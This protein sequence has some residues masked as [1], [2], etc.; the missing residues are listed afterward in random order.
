MNPLLEHAA[1]V[2]YHQ[3]TRS[4]EAGPLHRRTLLETGVSMTYPRFM[5]A[6]REQTSHFAVIPPDPV[7]GAADA[8]DPRQRS[9]YEAALEAAGM[10]QPLIVLAERCVDPAEPEPGAVV[11]PGT[12]ADVFHDV[13]DALTHLLHASDPDDTLY[14]A[15][16]AALEELHAVTRLLGS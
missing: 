1:R 10:T 9:L 14:S 13:H 16:A 5:K 3:P 8:W 11:G 7:I 2:L 12:A 4:M 6:V 15:V